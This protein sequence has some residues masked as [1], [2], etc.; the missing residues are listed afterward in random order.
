MSVAKII[1][2]SCASTKSFE[3]AVQNGVSRAAETIKHIQGAWVA[4]QKVLVEK[5]KVV[6]YRV[7]LRLTFLLESEK[8][9]KAEKQAKA[10]KA[11]KPAKA[12]KSGKAGK[13]K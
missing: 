10:D 6:E 13:Q 12:E 2:I 4:E 9:E 5:G 1:E 11:E 7:T 8:A 3:D